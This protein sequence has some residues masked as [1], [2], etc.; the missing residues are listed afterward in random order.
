MSYSII[1]ATKIVNLPDGRILHLSRNG[2]NNDNAGREK[3][4][5][6]A[7]MYS[8]EEFQKY[9]EHYTSIKSNEGFDLK[10]G[11]RYCNW[12][13]YGKHLE[14]MLKRSK[15]WDELKEDAL[16]KIKHQP[17]VKYLKS[18]DVEVKET[19][20]KKTFTPEEWDQ[21]CYDYWYT[22]KIT[23]HYDFLYNIEDVM[24][25]T[26]FLKFSEFHIA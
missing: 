14:R 3:G 13:D 18:V 26:E 21:V 17:Y 7:K 15:T 25:H 8:P 16:T 6:S 24:S 4:V 19:G 1:F 20:E 23:Y 10:I 5:Y 11:S 12:K 2:C 22:A 9:I